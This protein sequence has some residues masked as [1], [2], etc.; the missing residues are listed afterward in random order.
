MFEAWGAV[1]VLVYAMRAVLALAHPLMPFVTEELWQALPHAGDALIIAPWPRHA[2]AIDGT[3]LAQFQVR[4]V[5]RPTQQPL[6]SVDLHEAVFRDSNGHAP[7]LGC[8][9]T[10]NTWPAA[11]HTLGRIRG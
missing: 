6:P 11:F 1:Q 9:L 10:L 7:G 5:Q 4:P 2:G 3:A 8:I